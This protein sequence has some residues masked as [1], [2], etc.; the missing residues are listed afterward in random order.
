[1]IYLID[2][3]DV[4][5]L[6]VLID[7]RLSILWFI[8]HLKQKKKV[9]RGFFF[10]KSFFWGKKRSGGRKFFCEPREKKITFKFEMPPKKKN[11]ESTPPE[12]KSKKEE[13]ET[14]NGIDEKWPNAD[15]WKKPPMLHR[16]GVCAAVSRSPSGEPSGVCAV[17]GTEI[18]DACSYR[19]LVFYCCA[20]FC[21][22]HAPYDYNPDL[23]D[24][25]HELGKMKQ[26]MGLPRQK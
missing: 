11:L 14:K 4:D 5:S 23:N 12:K 18:C 10:L 16:T 20:V 2:N 19:C 22:N 24:C 17:C 25:P 9:N 13:T 21:A 8:S 7:G 6:R 1:V 15:K 3:S 26:I